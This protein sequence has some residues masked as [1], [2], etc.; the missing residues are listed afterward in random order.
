MLKKKLPI[1]KQLIKITEEF[2][3]VYINNYTSKK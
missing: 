3:K 2:H 1:A